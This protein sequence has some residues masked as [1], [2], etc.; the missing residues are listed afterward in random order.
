MLEKSVDIGQSATGEQ[1]ASTK[2]K[3]LP[4]PGRMIINRRQLRQKLPLCDRTIL[5]MERRSEFPKR[6][7]VGHR[8]Y[9]DLHEVDAWIAQCQQD[10]HQARRPG[11]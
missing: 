8:V 3:L 7:L 6:F 4:P 5:E 10:G 2:R 9:W 1:S 11:D